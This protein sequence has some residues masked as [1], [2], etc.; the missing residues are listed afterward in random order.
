MDCTPT[1]TDSTGGIGPGFWR[2]IPNPSL[3][4]SYTG[5][6]YQWGDSITAT[7]CCRN[8]SR[9]GKTYKAQDRTTMIQCKQCLVKNHRRDP[10]TVIF[11]PIPEADDHLQQHKL[12]GGIPK[13]AKILEAVR[14][15]SEGT[16]KDRSN[17]ACPR[18]NVQGSVIV[19]AII[20]QREL[21]GDQGDAEDP[22]GIPLSSGVTDHRNVG[23]TRGR[24]RVG[25][26]SGR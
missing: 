23:E 12:V 14:H 22:D 25:V 1:S 15:D 3:E 8:V 7:T 2:S 6:K 19:G 10:T 24:W 18:R 5:A 16:G 9:G 26:L 20:W 13:Y 4:A 11:V 17:N 21:G